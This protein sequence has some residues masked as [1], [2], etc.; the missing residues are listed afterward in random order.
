MPLPTIDQLR[1]LPEDWAYIPCGKDKRPYPPF[2]DDWTNKS[3]S[4]DVVEKEI[5]EGRCFAVGVLSGPKS[6]GLLFVDHD[7]KGA[8]DELALLGVSLADLPKSWACTSGRDARCQIIYKVPP[9]FWERIKTKKL[10]ECKTEGWNE[11]KKKTEQE[12]LELR[13]DGC[14]SIVLGVH[15]DTGGYRWLKGRGPSE[16]ELRAAPQVLIDQMLIKQKPLTPIIPFPQ[17]NS[18]DSDIDRAR[19]FL[20]S[21]HPS[22]A[23]DYDTWMNVGMSLHSVSDLLLADWDNWSSSSSKYEVG[24]CEKKWRS[25]KSGGIT[26][27]FLGHLAKKSGWKSEKKSAPRNTQIVR[28]SNTQEKEQEEEPNPS[29]IQTQ[30]LEAAELLGLLRSRD[31]IRYNIFTQ[32]IEIQETAI[33]GIDRFYLQLAEMGYKVPKAL[34]EDC[35]VQVAQENKFD[36]VKNYLDHV[37]ETVEP[38]CIDYLA[39]TYLRPNDEAGTLYDAMMKKTLIGAVKRVFEP[40]CKH[41]TATVLIGDQGS[42]KS[43]FWKVLGGPFFSDALGDISTKDDLLIL[44]KSWIMEWAE[45]DAITSKKQSGVIKA[46]LSQSTDMFRVPYG[47]ATEDFPRRSLIV[48]SSNKNSFLVDE[49]GN[50]RFWCIQTTKNTLDPIDTPALLMERDSLWSAAVKAY[51]AGETNFLTE[52]DELKVARENLDYMVDHPWQPVIEKWIYKQLAGDVITTEGILSEAVE[53]PIDRQTK[54]DQMTCA[55]ILKRLGYEKQRSQVF[56]KRQWV[57][58]KIS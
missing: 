8:G 22:D 18:T 53:K 14:Q 24:A 50:R 32:A 15:P 38:T 52:Q 47:R 46:F 57:W 48:G 31:S 29:A 44:T 9:E 1:E 42:R 28:R 21:V 55:D 36:P 54:S 6:N 43:T 11:Y 27:G 2:A 13:W 51:K 41:D 4:R 56:G 33:Q 58:T 7:G 39:T 26:L 25:F 20:K 23:D 35:L 49:T 12:K 16:E 45:I 10:Y 37:S 17:S 40:G 19:S 34:A 30:K 5:K 3:V